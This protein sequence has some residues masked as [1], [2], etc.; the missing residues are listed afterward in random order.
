MISLHFK[1]QYLVTVEE[2]L[3]LKYDSEL[4]VT[5]YIPPKKTLLR[6]F[7]VTAKNYAM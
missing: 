7:F 5:R 4:L 3:H 2:P 1:Q 6:Y